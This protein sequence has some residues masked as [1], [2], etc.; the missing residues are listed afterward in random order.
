M[1]YKISV[2]TGGT[3]TDVVVTNGVGKTIIGKALTTHTRVF[4]GLS[5]AIE[6]A[7]SQLDLGLGELLSRTNLLVYGTTRAT[8]AIVTR[9]VA[10]TAF[11]TTQGFPDILVLKEGGKL[12]GF[13]FSTDYPAPYIPRRWTFEVEERVNSEGEVVVPLNETS[14]RAVLEQLKEQSFE[15]IA[16]CLLWSII[17]SDHERRIGELI[18]EILPGVPYTLSH[19]LAPIVREYRRASATA[20]DASLKPLMQRHFRDFETDLREAGYENELLV[21]TSVGGVMSV[22]EVIDAPINTAKSGPAMAPVAALTYSKMEGMGDNV[23]VCDTG[24]T[25]YDVALSRD[26]EIIYSRDTWMGPPWE[27]D[28][29]GISSVDIRSLGAGGGSIAW[30]DSGGLLRV[31]PQSAGSE[32]GPAC[33]GRGGENPTLSDAACVLGYFDPDYFLGGRM[34]LDV[35]AARNAIGK[36]A[37]KM[38]LS[39]EQAAWG[40]LCL[41]SDMMV[42][43]VNEL[44]VAQGINPSESTI[45]AGGGA[46]GIN[47]M[48]ISKELNAKRVVLPKVASALSA[49]GMQFANIVKEETGS[50]ITSSARFDFEGV[51]QLLDQLEQRLLAF[52]AGLN[53]AADSEYRIEYIAEARYQAQ[54]WDLDTRLPGTR[55]KDRDNLEEF[56]RT[57]HDVHERVFAV[58]DEDSPIECINWKARLIVPLGQAVEFSNKIDYFPAENP[59]HFRECFFGENGF[60]ETPIYT[61]DILIV[62]TVINGPAIIE[63]PTTTLVVFPDMSVQISDSGNYLLNVNR[64]GGTSDA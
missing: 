1:G 54:V 55:I 18:E 33:Y 22:E 53:R 13:G 4:D 15:A 58:R 59:S 56:V 61:P 7:A 10:K 32:P 50:L 6:N 9:N 52:L 8:N 14:V 12:D 42:K 20:I 47:V 48:Q 38:E 64:T 27:G 24:G 46:A 35:S 29:L 31:G 25:T 39:I 40:V 34:A 21:S 41:A 5:Q 19:R 11:L 16:V 45:V 28:L 2:D 30:V 44:T 57:F 3:F 43:E 51:N 49:S 62:G 37:K 63:E 17:H 26:G 36:I 23:I 60:A